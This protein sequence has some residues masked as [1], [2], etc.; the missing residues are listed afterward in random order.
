MFLLRTSP[1]SVHFVL[2]IPLRF[3][4]E[5]DRR[6]EFLVLLLQLIKFVLVLC[7]RFTRTF[8]R[9]VLRSSDFGFALA[10]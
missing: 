8:G 6:R 4:C 5:L 2:G 10:G 9:A 1:C 7:R 3:E